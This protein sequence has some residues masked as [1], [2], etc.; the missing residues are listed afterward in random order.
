MEWIQIEDAKI[1]EWSNDMTID[2]IEEKTGGQTFVLIPYFKGEGK[3]I[4]GQLWYS[5]SRDFLLKNGIQPLNEIAQ[6]GKDSCLYDKLF[7]DENLYKQQAIL[8]R[9][10]MGTVSPVLLTKDPEGE[11]TLWGINTVEGLHFRGCALVKGLCKY[12][13]Y[14]R[15][16]YRGQLSESLL[17]EFL[18]GIPPIMPVKYNFEPLPSKE[19]LEKQVI[20]R[21]IT[22]WNMHDCSLCG[23]PCGYLFQVIDNKVKVSYDR[24]CYCC[25]CPSYSTTMKDVIRHL[26]M[27]TNLNVINEYKAFWGI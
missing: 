5:E 15:P 20:S 22:E 2:T 11:V 26:E 25:K 1:P 8:G 12:I 18:S 17:K 6:S 4:G 23:Y 21:G 14:V 24:G 19:F 9:R 7:W 10:F 27:Q 3:N 13:K 16:M